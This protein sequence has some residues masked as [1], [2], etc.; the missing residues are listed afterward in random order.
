MISP[1]Y[2]LVLAA[3]AAA[4]L[5]PLASSAQAQAYPTRPITIMVPLAAGTGMDSLVRLYGEKLSQR[6]GKPVVVDN[7]PGAGL[8]LA[9]AAVAAAPADGYTLLVATSGP[10]AIGPAIYKKLNYDARNDFVPI[11]FYVRS[12]FILIANP[13][14]PFKTLPEFMKHAKESA[15]PLNYS[16]VGPGSPQHLVM[17][18]VKHRFG[19][20][21]THVPYR[22]SGQ[23]VTDT[24]AGH[25]QVGFAEAGA[26]I[27]VIRD[28]KVRALAVSATTRLPLL[29][30]VPPFSEA[31]GAPDFEAVSWHILF[32]PAKTPREIVERLH[33]EMKEIMADPEMQ[34]RAAAIG[35]IPQKVPSIEETQAYVRSEQDKWGALVKAV[36]MEGT[37]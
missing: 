23:A 35:L 13:D 10:M 36:G 37:Q 4:S 33:A 27:P 9:T 11:A 21:M 28:G 15:T 7:R 1:A 14:L 20:P 2:G 25:V 18:L 26:S 31:A 24:A 34:Q 17:E 22:N 6:L 30:D 29:P 8:T 3:L 19:L 5:T 32:A 12:P 16:S